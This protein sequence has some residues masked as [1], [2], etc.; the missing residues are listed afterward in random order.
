MSRR[1]FAAGRRAVYVQVREMVSHAIVERAWAQDDGND[2][3]ADYHDGRVSAL[4]QALAAID[5]EAVGS[6]DALVVH[7]NS[8]IAEY[9]RRSERE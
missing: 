3:R 8:L 9:R 2:A 5:R 7:F 4:V 1:H 6:V